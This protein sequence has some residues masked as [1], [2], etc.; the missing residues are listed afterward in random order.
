M[1]DN[2]PTTA[3]EEL[4]SR[5]PH[6]YNV[7][8]KKTVLY[9]LLSI[10]AQ[11]HEYKL[12]LIDRLY[13]ALG[14]EDTYDEDLEWK[15][16]SLLNLYRH[17]NESYDDYRSRL[18]I[19]Y[20]SLVG[21]TAEAIKYAVATTIGISSNPVLIDQYIH[22][23]D[24]WEYI[25]ELIPKEDDPPF[26]PTINIFKTNIDFITNKPYET[27]KYGA[28]VVTVDLSINESIA[29]SKSFVYNVI[30]KTKASGTNPYLLF[31]YISDDIGQIEGLDD[32][33]LI[34]ITEIKD[35]EGRIVAYRRPYFP[36]L[37]SE[38]KL[39][40]D[41]KTTDRLSNI[42]YYPDEVFDDIHKDDGHEIANTKSVF[43]TN[44]REGIGRT[45]IDMTLN[46]T[47]PSDRFIDNIKFNIN[48]ETD[49]VRANDYYDTLIHEVQSNEFGYLSNNTQTYKPVV[50]NNSSLNTDFDTNIVV[51]FE[52]QMDEHEDI[53]QQIIDDQI[54]IAKST[55]NM[56]NAGTNDDVFGTN[57]GLITNMF[58][59]ADKI[60]TE[61]S[62]FAGTD[63]SEISSTDTF[64]DILTQSDHE[65]GYLAASRNSFLAVLN[66][67]S[68]LN[69]DVI[70]SQL[71]VVDEVDDNFVDEIIETIQDSSTIKSAKFNGV[72]G[73]NTTNGGLFL[74]KTLKTNQLEEAD[75]CVDVIH[76]L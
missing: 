37:N 21:G 53:I 13:S 44:W 6:I 49:D 27:K 63:E 48:I 46:T 56:Y 57:I 73:S 58:M 70:L 5:F 72:W 54:N 43:S 42:D 7:Y 12:G 11:N 59:Q 64:S 61:I 30:N 74:N 38:H 39:N 32:Y 71:S 8:D 55:T 22:V 14:I 23:Y 25:G 75:I 50:G 17:P 65:F 31:L 20:P 68:K 1:A 15:W 67:N 9:A 51:E 60:F 16:G 52:H 4:Q 47:E 69:I 62:E 45:N 41:F 26:D 2:S 28:F 24:A 29:N 76:Y 34:N 35:D 19:V 10:Y 40:I 66:N 3:L 33:D 36:S 18:E